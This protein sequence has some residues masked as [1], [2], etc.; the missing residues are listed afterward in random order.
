MMVSEFETK[1]TLESVLKD[2]ED[3][4]VARAIIKLVPLK[5]KY[6]RMCEE[7]DNWADEQAKIEENRLYP[8]I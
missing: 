4:E 8:E 7:F 2:L 1:E 3:G 5:N 6:E